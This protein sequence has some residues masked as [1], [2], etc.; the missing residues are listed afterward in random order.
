MIGTLRLFIVLRTNISVFCFGEV[1]VVLVAVVV[2]VV[3][4]VVAV[5]VVVGQVYSGQGHPSGQPD[6]HGHRFKF[7]FWQFG[8]LVL[9]FVSG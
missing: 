3:V 8:S 9:I 1:V 2:V 7:S 5:V 6:W 4:V